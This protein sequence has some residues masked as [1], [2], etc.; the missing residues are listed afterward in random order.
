MVGGLN[1][2]DSQLLNI[3]AVLVSVTICMCV[4]LTFYCIMHKVVDTH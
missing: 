3:K 2:E 4:V 1:K